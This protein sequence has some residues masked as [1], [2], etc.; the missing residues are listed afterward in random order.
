MGGDHFDVKDTHLRHCTV[1]ARLLQREY[2]TVLDGHE[3]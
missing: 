3:L 2:L 1:L